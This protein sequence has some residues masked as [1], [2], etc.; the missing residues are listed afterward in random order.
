[1]R[2]KRAILLS[3]VA[4]ILSACTP[5]QI[6]WWQNLDPVQRY[7]LTVH[8]VQPMTCDGQVD[9]IWPASS[10]GWAHRIVY[11]ESRGIATAQNRRSSAAGCFQLLSMHAFRFQRHGYTWA[12][13]YNPRANVLAALDLFT[14]A[15]TRPWA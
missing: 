2:M 1:M 6:A 4:L 14:E 12:D 11:R 8:D 7:V 9:A 3:F 13:R 5:E 15:G 10:R